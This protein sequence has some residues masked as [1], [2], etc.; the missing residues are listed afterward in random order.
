MI[1]F[2]TYAR[3]IAG[4]SDLVFAAEASLRG[5]NIIF[6]LYKA[7]TGMTPFSKTSTQRRKS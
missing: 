2:L 7:K 5:N 4:N 6:H 1:V 3:D